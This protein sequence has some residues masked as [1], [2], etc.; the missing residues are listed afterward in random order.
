[1]RHTSEILKELG[2]NEEA[3]ESTKRAFLNHLKNAARA[4]EA[5]KSTYSSTNA[6]PPAAPIPQQ[7]SFDFSDQTEVV[8][9]NDG[10]LP[11]KLNL[12]RE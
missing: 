3:P 8:E 12:H 10:Q 1:M 9:S 2:F 11:L 6:P 7:L 4:A 5:E